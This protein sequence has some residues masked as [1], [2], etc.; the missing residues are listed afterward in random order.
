ME[1]ERR[2]YGDRIVADPAILVGKPVIKGTR[3]AVEHVL[4]QLADSPDLQELFEVYPDL[5]L[6]DLQACLAYAQALAAGEPTT[7][8]AS[9]KEGCEVHAVLPSNIVEG[10]LA[11]T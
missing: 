6:E 7:P 5:T 4:E 11:I 2:P 1:Q 9:P 3:I 10:R 8:Q